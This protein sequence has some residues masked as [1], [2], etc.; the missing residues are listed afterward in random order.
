[1]KTLKKIKLLIIFFC[2]MLIPIVMLIKNGAMKTSYRNIYKASELSAHM[3]SFPENTL[4]LCD[5]DDTLIT[6]VSKTF[7][8]PYK[9]MIDDIKSSQDKYANYQE[10]ISTWRLSRKVK[11]T[12]KEWPSVINT[13]K[14]GFQVF[15]LTKMDTG[16]VGKIHSIEQWRYSELKSLDIRFTKKTSEIEK[17]KG[18]TFFKGIIFTGSCKKS[19]A[20]QNHLKLTNFDHIVMVDDR[21]EHLDDMSSLCKILNIP[22]TGFCFKIPQVEINPDIP[23]IQ[24]LYL[25]EKNIWLEDADA[26]SVLTR[27]KQKTHCQNVAV[28]NPQ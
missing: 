16:S 5:I 2:T 7:A 3:K 13:I 24:H 20:L 25:T 28:Y 11:L 18:S 9:K 15:G 26:D 12:D 10:I 19:L 23:K 17:N 14:N 6:P 22:F 27:T 21:T 1:M 4:V 8:S